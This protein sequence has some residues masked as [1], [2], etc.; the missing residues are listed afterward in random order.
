MQV[1][2]IANARATIGGPSLE[3][4]TP[5]R[6]A[7]FQ[8]TT[9]LS[10]GRAAPTRPAADAVSGTAGISSRAPP[11]PAAARNRRRD[12]ACLGK[13]HGAALVNNWGSFRLVFI[14]HSGCGPAEVSRAFEP[15]HGGQGSAGG[16]ALLTL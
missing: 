8:S 9:T 3:S 16:A 4:R 11:L 10:T 7:S 12:M 13:L 1:W 15:V 14:E 6:N 2:P 5:C